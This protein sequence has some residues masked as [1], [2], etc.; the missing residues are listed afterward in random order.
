MTA[1]QLRAELFREISPLLDNETAMMRVLSFVKTLSPANNV[2][3]E[4][5]NK[6]YKEIP[7]SPEIKKWRGCASFTDSEIENDPRLKAILSR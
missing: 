6:P 5:K 4:K 1:V 2:V 7:V 3:P